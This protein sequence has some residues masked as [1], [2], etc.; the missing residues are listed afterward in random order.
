MKKRVAVL[1]G[2]IMTLT[3]MTG[4]GKETEKAP[5]AEEKPAKPA[6]KP[7]SM[8]KKG[9]KKDGFEMVL[10]DIAHPERAFYAEGKKE[11]L[12]GDANCDGT[13]DLADAV[14]IMQSLANP[15]KYGLNGTDERHITEQGIENGDVDKSIAGLTSNDALRIQEFL[16]GK[17]VSLG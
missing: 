6:A 10:T 16:L 3:V 11:Y 9:E 2:V 13:V 8:F 14:I 17:D 4:C 5:A 1:L 12:A 7:F 15:D